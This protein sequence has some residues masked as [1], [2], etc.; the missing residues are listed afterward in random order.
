M[1]IERQQVLHLWL[2]SS[3]LDSAVLGWAF[4]DGAKGAGPTPAQDTAPYAT[5]VAALV[6]GWHLLQVSQLIP[7]PPGSERETS[8]LN[9]EF[10]FTRLVALPA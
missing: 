5:G 10:V 6:D 4:F 9:H 1:N 8:F 7:A 2:S 3:A